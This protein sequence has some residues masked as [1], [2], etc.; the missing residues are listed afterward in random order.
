MNE[1]QEELA[2]NAPSNDGCS[3]TPTAVSPRV[4]RVTVP[5]SLPIIIPFGGKW[6]CME[7]NSKKA[8]I[9]ESENEVI[10]IPARGHGKRV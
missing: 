3:I 7:Q 10:E 9:K 1:L 5:G 4:Q 2:D 6:E 8:V